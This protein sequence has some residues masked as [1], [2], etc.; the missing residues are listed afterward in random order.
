LQARCGHLPATQALLGRDRDVRSSPEF[1][2]SFAEAPPPPSISS[3]AY[4]PAEIDHGRDRPFRRHDTGRPRQRRPVT[5]VI[6][7]KQRE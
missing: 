2:E 5:L 7:T 1:I 6:D 4:E 3:T